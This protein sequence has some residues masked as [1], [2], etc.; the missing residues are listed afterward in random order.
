MALTLFAPVAVG[1][2]GGFSWE[3]DRLGGS[4]F[5]DLRAEMDVLIGF[6]VC[7]HPLD[8]TPSYAPAPVTI[9][10]YRPPASGP[11]DLCRTASAEAVRGFENNA[12]VEA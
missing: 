6:S 1:D 9:T 12:L 3:A 10:R 7:P 11:D 5:V 4:D 8:P 2:D